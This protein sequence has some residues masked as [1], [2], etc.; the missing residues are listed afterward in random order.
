MVPGASLSSVREILESRLG[1]TLLDLESELDAHFSAR[2][3]EELE[4]NAARVTAEV[5]ERSRRELADHLNQAVRRMRQA[6]DGANLG[7]ALLD[8][9]APFAAG[10]ALFRVDHTT[11]FGEGI[12]GVPEESA[13]RFRTREIALEGA[14]ALAEAVRSRD[15]VTAAATPAEVSEELAGLAAD[16]ASARVFLY[17]VEAGDRVPALVCAWGE[18]QG[19]A[20]EL[21]AQISAAALC[22]LPARGHL[23]GIAPAPN[24]DNGEKKVGPSAWDALSSEEQQWHLRAQRSARVQVAEIRLFEPEAVQAGRARHD[25]YG[26]VRV[27]IDTARE[28]FRKRFF[29]ATPTMVD[30]L[31]LELVRTLA[32]DDPE[33][34]GNDYPGPL[35]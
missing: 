33:L 21:L 27:R 14:P 17:P 24:G 12:R 18:V 30:Y 34:L 3:A 2:V 25:L 28:S 7:A 20:M 8:A 10:V 26:A 16:S 23:L 22:A 29:S 19:S 1:K 13:A 4:R 32:N 15:P 9:A 5:R 31:H 11:A 6:P 35:A